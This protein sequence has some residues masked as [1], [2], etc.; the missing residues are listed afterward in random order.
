[1]KLSDDEKMFKEKYP[2]KSGYCPMECNSFTKYIVFLSIAK[3]ISSTSRTGNYL[4]RF[5]CVEERDK[6]FAMGIAMTVFGTFGSIPYPLI[7]GAIADSACLIWEQSCGGKGNCWLYDAHKFRYYLH[8]AAFTFMTIGSIFDAFVIY[9][10]K[11]MRNLY[12]DEDEEKG[13]GK[14]DDTKAGMS[15][16]IALRSADPVMNP[17]TSSPTTT[18]TVTTTANNNLPAIISH[19]SS[20]L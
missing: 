4:V 1:M 6:S 3:F 15:E 5:R 20:D 2:V 13:T 14:K 19:E 16:S 18:T 11:D 17:A 7:F 8:G 9:F 12:D 10:A